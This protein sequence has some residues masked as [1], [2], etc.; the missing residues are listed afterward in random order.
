MTIAKRGNYLLQSYVEVIDEYR[1]TVLHIYKIDPILKYNNRRSLKR[2]RQEW[3][4][5]CNCKATTWGEFFV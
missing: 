4:F 1:L 2:K 5:K 3:L